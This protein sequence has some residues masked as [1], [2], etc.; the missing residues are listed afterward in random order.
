ML[1]QFSDHFWGKAVGVPVILDHIFVC[2]DSRIIL[3]Q[4]L[5]DGLL[6]D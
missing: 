2:F 4:G 5:H 3:E 6:K 1:I